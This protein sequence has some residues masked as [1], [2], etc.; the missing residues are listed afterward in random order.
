MKVCTYCGTPNPETTRFCTECG[1]KLPEDVESQEAGSASSGGDGAGHEPASAAPA[2]SAAMPQSP[3]I[4][5]GSGSEG[6]G[7]DYLD[8]VQNSSAQYGAQ[9]PS[10]DTPGEGDSKNRRNGKTIAIIAC[11]AV[12]AVVVI[13]ILAFSFSSGGGG[14]KTFDVTEDI[15]LGYSG[16]DGYATAYIDAGG[17]WESDALEYLLVKCDGDYGEAYEQ[18]ELLDDAVTYEISPNENLS[19]GDTVTLSATIDQDVIADLP[20]ELVGDS[21]TFEVSGLIEAV[22]LDL[23]A[24]FSLEYDGFAP[25]ASADIADSSYEDL[26]Y[27]DVEFE[28]DS[29]DNLS[30]GDII[31]V[32]AVYDEDEL[33]AD[34]YVVENASKQ[35]TVDGLTSYYLTLDSIPEEAMD[36]MKEQAQIEI[37]AEAAEW[38]EETRTY[39]SSEYIGCYFLTP[40]FDEI[41]ISDFGNRIALVYRI[42][43]W[44]K[45]RGD[46]SYYQA[47]TYDNLLQ[48]SD[49]SY[50]VDI[51]GCSRES[52]TFKSV[53]ETTRTNVYLGYATLD[54]LFNKHVTAYTDDYEYESTVEEE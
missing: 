20:V 18:F 8:P 39:K 35:I 42:S 27:L 51:D 23:F 29:M 48:L 33:M 53:S 13:G 1:A 21:R 36:K 10:T 15:A 6:T 54:S 38:Y 37:E 19:N 7:F 46:F 47:Y 40:K 26:D 17:S 25:F 24:N 11:V 22:V 34:G 9:G 31:T 30:N 41:S 49:G 12:V 50:S 14:K 28:C 32:T 4:P 5:Y 44:D 2:A 43:A 16:L 45:Y 3:D 52:D